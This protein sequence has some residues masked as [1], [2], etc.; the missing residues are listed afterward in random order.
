MKKRLL[1]AL[2]SM[3]IVCCVQGQDPRERHYFYEILAP[4]HEPKPLVAGFASRRVVESLDR[5]LYAMPALDGQSVYL[6]WRLLASDAPNTS[7][8]VYREAVGKVKRLT[9]KP[10]LSTCDFVDEFPVAEA[11]YWVEV[12]GAAKTVALS[13]KNE[14]EIAQLK[15]YTSIPLKTACKAG[16]IALA[17]LNGDGQYDY[18]IRTPETNVDPGMPGDTTG[19][20]YQISAYLH[21]GTYLWTHDM[22]PGIEPGIWYSPFIVYDFDGDGKSEVAI[23]SAGT[24][25]VKNEKGRV[26]GGSEYLS[27]LNGMTGQ[28]IDRVNWPE[29]NDRYGNLIRQNRNQM[30]VAYLD[31]KTPFIL[32]AR[33]TYKLMVV[34]AWM[35]SNGRLRKVWRWDGDEENPVVRSMGAHSMV[36]ADVDQDGRDEIL[37]GSC[38]LDD[39]GTL[40]WS[41]GLGHSDKAYL[42]KL[43]PDFPGLQVFMVSEPKKEDGRGVSVV[44]AATGKLMWKIGQ[45]TYH[46]GDGMVA[47]FDA[48]HAGLECFASEDRKGGSTDRYLLTANGT[49]LGVNRVD[50]PGCR[51]WIWWDADLLR[52]TFKGDNNRWGAGSTTSGKTLSVWKWKDKVLTAGIEG[53]ILMMAD[54]EGDWREELITAL[55]G[56]IR[57]Y[58][59][60]IPAT[61]RRVTL[62]Q[63]ALYR[64]Y[65]A[66]RSMGYP[67]A[68]VPSFYLGE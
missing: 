5:G 6:S 48:T 25:Y 22:G 57:I 47:D 34:D 45:T 44:D 66:H 16:K 17:D 13:D 18:V 56:E 40:L 37:L 43:H 61:D 19:K 42:C 41:S 21:D 51:N 38:M 2:A 58:R 35:L 55:P 39:N 7:F 52:E 10:L 59:T 53:D 33:G 31:G 27:V 4:K 62:M 32:A 50:I 29:R 68:P 26:C 14:V 12:V 64:S 15:T 1:L 8:H 63:D 65:I 23:K 49:R 20:T 24:D 3:G 54:M 60:N 67:Q 36:T 11:V 28:E 30:G 9:K 46:V